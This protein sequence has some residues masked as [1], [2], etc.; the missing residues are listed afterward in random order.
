MATRNSPTSATSIGAGAVK[1]PANFKARL[2]T[3][4]TCPECK[5]TK[6]VSIKTCIPSGKS[7][8]GIYS[9]CRACVGRRAGPRRSYVTSTTDPRK[10]ADRIATS[11]YETKLPDPI[12][13]PQAFTLAVRRLA[14]ELYR[15][16]ED[17]TKDREL[18][19]VKELLGQACR[20]PG[21]R[22]GDGIAPSEET[23]FRAFFEVLKHRLVGATSLAEI[24]DD[25]IA[26]LC[27]GHERTLVLA[28]RNSGKSSLTQVYL[29]H[30]L[31]RDP[32]KIIVVVSAGTTLARRALRTVRQWL[33]TVPL[34]NHL[35][36]DENSLDSAQQFTTPQAN[37]RIGASQSVSSFGITAALAGYR[38]DLVVADD[39]EQRATQGPEAIER[40]EMTAS[41]L[42][43][44][45]NPNGRIV[46][47]GTPQSVSSY[48]L[49]LYRSGDFETTVARLFDEYQPEPG[50]DISASAK[51]Y[52]TRLESRWPDRWSN[53]E[54]ERKRRTMPKAEWELHWRINLDT[55]FTTERPISMKQFCVV[56]WDPL[57][58]NFPRIV[59]FGGQRLS[60]LPDFTGSFADPNDHFI[61]PESVSSESARYITTVAAIDPSSGMQGRDELGLAVVSVTAQSKGVI[62]CLTGIRGA[63]VVDT[64][65][66]AAA[67]IV[68]YL[69]THVIVEQRADGL[70]ASQLQSVLQRRGFPTLVEPV[71][72]GL[73]KGQ[74]IVSTIQPLA[75]DERLIMLESVLTADDATMTVRQ[76]TSVTLD[77]RSIVKNDDRIDALAYALAKVAPQLIADD[78]ESMPMVSAEMLERLKNLPLRMGGF[79][80]DTLD[81]LYGPNEEI[82]RLQLR[83]EE[84]MRNQE[85]EIRAGRIDPR[86][87]MYI[88]N[89]RNELRK[90]QGASRALPPSI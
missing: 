29:A 43:H 57:S 76:V 1:L 47:L 82:E 54:L 63:N 6:E 13:Q 23:A 17:P 15:L 87:A 21:D 32:L 27:G 24:H 9:P 20:M 18:A 51:G 30:Q 88:E 75:A 55:D 53:E 33:E 48:Y 61:G 22:G 16:A 74:R 19:R 83:L 59:R 5:E 77:G 7:P 35:R 58:S 3:Q 4:W 71:F 80:D 37:G 60:H 90:L 64:L 69:P 85:R 56:R 25:L 46:Y 28:S 34:L 52:S 38:A 65:N 26:A 31:F 86:F 89:T 8:D 42:P 73:N 49:K 72:S 66:K 39:L 79:E 81:C 10:L 40:L 44:L 11:E 62:R 84:L 14:V 50:V 45:L 2:G 41:E 36:P 70:W 67:L 12:T 68:Q 78:A